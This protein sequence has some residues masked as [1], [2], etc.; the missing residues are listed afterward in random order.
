MKK[1]VLVDNNFIDVKRNR[2]QF[3]KKLYEITEGDT[4]CSVNMWEL[5]EKLQFTRRMTEQVVQYLVDE[6][7]VKYFTLG[8]G[9]VITHQGTVHIEKTLSEPDKPT[10]EFPPVNIINVQNMV[11]SQIQQ[12][13]FESTQTLSSSTLDCKDIFNFIIELKDKLHELQLDSSNAQEV[14]ADIST[15]ES[16][17]KSSRPKSII[18]KESLK[19]IKT[20]LEGAAGNILASMLLEKLASINF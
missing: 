6:N 18:I 19:G 15:I 14:A 17:I 8:G 16:Q 13:T 9:I 20:I 4:L 2:Y 7:L 1:V 3:L 10:H 11:G 5:G 12:S